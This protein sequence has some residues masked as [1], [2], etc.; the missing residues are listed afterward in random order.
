M[1][2]IHFANRKV[3]V[4]VA[5]VS[6]RVG[7]SLIQLGSLTCVVI[8]CDFR[9]YLHLQALNLVPL[10]QIAYGRSDSGEDFYK[11]LFCIGSADQLNIRII[12]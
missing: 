9:W 10:P 6:V 11:D 2:A 4:K 3:T 12:W 5:T 1:L 8:E 7:F